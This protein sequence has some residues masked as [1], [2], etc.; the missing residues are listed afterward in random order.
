MLDGL[1]VI[2][3]LVLI[4]GIPA[5]FVILDFRQPSPGH[6]VGRDGRDS[7]VPGAMQRDLMDDGGE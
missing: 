5:T 2:G 3:V 7:I 4:L 6:R 1:I